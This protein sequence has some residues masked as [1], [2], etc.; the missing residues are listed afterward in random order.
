M[1]YYPDYPQELTALLN[2]ILISHTLIDCL[3][4]ILSSSEYATLA[5]FY[6]AFNPLFNCPCLA[7]W[8]SMLSSVSFK[9]QCISTTNTTS[10]EQTKTQSSAF[11]TSEEELTTEKDHTTP[12]KGNI[13]WNIIFAI[14]L[15]SV[16]FIT[17]CI[18]SGV[19][20]GKSYALMWNWKT[21]GSLW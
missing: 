5:V 11:L 2:E 4:Q 20:Y 21:A 18:L 15:S 10:D 9:T 13:S 19:G 7:Q 1:T 6:E 3:R 14:S 12:P 8:K 17:I 16:S